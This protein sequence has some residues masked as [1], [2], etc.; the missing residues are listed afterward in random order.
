M[1]KTFS[2]LI[3]FLLLFSISGNSFC[4]SEDNW[5][6]SIKEILFRKEK[7]NI[8]NMFDDNDESEIY[9]TVFFNKGY[10][11]GH[12]NESPVIKKW[13][14]EIF[15]Q[16]NKVLNEAFSDAVTEVKN[17]SFFNDLFAEGLNDRLKKSPKVFAFV[18]LVGMDHLVFIPYF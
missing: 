12:R 15:S 18:V 14:K 4:Y 13:R 8:I 10:L 11:P 5:P 6:D 17:C 9:A 3:L 16:L 7:N 2:V 1:S